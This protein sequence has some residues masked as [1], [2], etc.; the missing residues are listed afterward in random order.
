MTDT[1]RHIPLLAI[2]MGD[3]AGV[4]PEIAVQLFAEESIFNL[5]RTLLIGNS[6]ILARAIKMS[7]L[8]FRVNE[9]DDVA[10]ARFERGV[11]DLYHIASDS[12]DKIC[13]GEIS[14]ESGDLAFRSVKVSIDLALEGKVDG[15]V[16]GPIQK[17]ALHKA[18]HLFAG[19][20]EI[21]AHYTG[22]S[23][24][25]MLLADEDFRIIHATTHVSLREACD[26]VKKERILDVIELLHEVLQKIGISNP[27]IGVAG[28]NPHS[29]DGGIFGREEEAEIT[30]AITEAKM[31]GIRAEGPVAPDILFMQ[32]AGG[33]YDGCVAMYHDQGHIPFKF[34][35]FRW[36]LREGKIDRAS[37][38][39]ITLG[40]PIV[41]TSVDHGTAFDIAGKGIA[42]P[43]A[44]IQAV[45]YA[46]KLIN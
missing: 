41:R 10:A 40:L 15:V 34:K 30:P 33:R 31:K 2:T 22:A 27:R 16:T 13:F 12:E 14:A 11:I 37:G 45:N 44:L 8:D 29:S 39:N 38:V 18:G 24:Y 7:G 32:A 43:D 23:K 1:A 36:N 19:H 17:E 26:L 20:T 21:F 4:G 42:C 5:C 6:R 28:L 3:P 25:A 46:V 9:I 35:S